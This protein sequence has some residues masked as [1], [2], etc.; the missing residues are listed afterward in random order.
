MAANMGESGESAAKAGDEEDIDRQ[1]KGLQLEALRVDLE[2][3]RKEAARRSISSPVALAVVTG[4]LGLIGASYSNHL[5]GEGNL[6]LERQRFEANRKLEREKFESSLTLQAIQTG[7]QEVATRNLLFLVDIGLISDPTGK[8][9]ALKRNPQAAP[10]LPTSTGRIS[11]APILRSSSA[12]DVFFTR[13]KAEL[14][15]LPADGE[16]VLTQLFEFIEQDK[17]L[18][19]IPQV[20]YVLA[21]IRHETGNAFRPITETGSGM[22]YEGRA[23]LGNVQPGDGPRFRGRGYILLTGRTNYRQFNTALGLEGTD[24]DLVANP[25]AALDPLI[26]YRIASIG[27]LRGS[28][29]GR[30][31]GYFVNEQQ[32]DY[33]KA[34]RVVNGSDQA[35]AI[36]SAAAKIESILRESLEKPR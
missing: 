26:A 12:R 19:N 27:M 7:N 3:K 35:E 2:L 22:A 13:Y 32:K 16:R 20:A 28:F 1:I 29:T 18:Q 10:V 34:R 11:L 25:E 21:T 24:K 5:Q 30:R 4:L 31:L 33:I 15:P 6:K 14:G 17:E 8:I 23:D 36:A 9:A